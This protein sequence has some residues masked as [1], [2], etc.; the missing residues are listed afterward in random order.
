MLPKV[1]FPPQPF[2]FTRNGEHRAGRNGRR[3]TGGAQ[4]AG[5]APG[6]VSKVVHMVAAGGAEA[7]W[8]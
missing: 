8:T 5:R 7:R 1:S 4:R 3:A 6:E 2:T